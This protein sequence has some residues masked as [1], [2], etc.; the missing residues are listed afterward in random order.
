M[1]VSPG[2]ALARFQHAFLDFQVDAMGREADS[3]AAAGVTMRGFLDACMAC[4]EIIGRKF[5]QGEYYLPQLVVAGEMF[6]TASARLRRA[7]TEDPIVLAGDAA[8]PAADIVLG[9]PRGDI[10]DLGK[11]IFSILARASGLSVHD[12]G[13]DVAPEDLVDSV[14]TTGA[15]VLGMSTLLTTA[16]DTIEEVVAML[17]ARG[18]RQQTFVIVGGGATDSSLV[19]KLGVDAQTRDAYQGVRLVRAFTE[20]GQKEAVA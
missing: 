10:H 12:L 9:T 6:K 11:N 8:P 15:A 5:E 1:T 19:E 16:F 7:T 20:T 3:L 13:A 4:M 17:E 2:H 18:L 14:A